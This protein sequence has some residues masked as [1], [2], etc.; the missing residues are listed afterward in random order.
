M[1]LLDCLGIRDGDV[2]SVAGAGG[3]TTLL[4][5]LATEARQ[6]GLRV[7]VTT[8]THMGSLP[9]E[10]TGPVLLEEEGDHA[11]GLAEA[12]H[13]EGR[14]TLIGRR[15]RADKLEGVPPDHVR[16]HAGGADVVL[17]EADGARGRSLKV[18]APHEP[19]VPRATTLFVVVAALDVLGEPLTEDRVHRLELVCSSTG[20]AVGEAVDEDTVVSCLRHALSYPSRVPPG[21]RAVVFLNKAEGDEAWQ[22]AVRIGRRLVPPYCFVVAGSA[23]SGGWRVWP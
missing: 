2:V 20:T 11:A 22:A 4:Y 10:V 14:A 19:V 3:K 6:A 21:A 23:R 8:T 9:E 5:R 15:I 13:R 7:L 17:V 1:S 18:P 16:A 12:L